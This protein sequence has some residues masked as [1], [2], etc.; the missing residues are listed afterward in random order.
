MFK[1]PHILHNSTS[2]TNR[3]RNVHLRDLPHH[4]VGSGLNYMDGEDAVDNDYCVLVFAEL[5][6]YRLYDS[7]V[8]VSIDCDRS[9]RFC[10]LLCWC[11]EETV[12]SAITSNPNKLTD[13]KLW[14]HM[15]NLHDVIHTN[16]QRHHPTLLRQ[17]HVP[18]DVHQHLAESKNHM[19]KLQV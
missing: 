8:A 5:H 15:L 6:D 10:M 3:V 19:S 17:A 18:L 2:R 13:R 14:W 16:Q 7:V 4:G 9:D 11:V 1:K 12:D